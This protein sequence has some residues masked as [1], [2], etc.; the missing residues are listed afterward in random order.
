MESENTYYCSAAEYN[1]ICTRLETPF[2]PEILCYWYGESSE[3]YFDYEYKSYTLT[4]EQA[5][6]ISQVLE[7]VAPSTLGTE[8]FLDYDWS[9][10]LESCSADMLL[11]RNDMEIA[12][13]ADT[14]YLVVYDGAEK[15]VY[16]V[17]SS[18]NNIL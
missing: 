8:F 17:P 3:D 13:R 14:Y 12:V 10:P 1:A 2:Q 7:T 6:V 18:L 4:N 15:L 16:T 5:A 9:V 11:R